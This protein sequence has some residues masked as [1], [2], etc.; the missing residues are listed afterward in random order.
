MAQSRLAARVAYRPV[1]HLTLYVGGENLTD[2]QRDPDRL[3]D[4]RPQLGR[5][6]Y[7]GLSGDFGADAPD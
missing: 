4:Q 3:G 7:V 5:T 2:V 1:S 6:F